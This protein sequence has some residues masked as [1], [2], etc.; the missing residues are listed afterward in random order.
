[1]ALAC[2]RRGQWVHRSR[3]ADVITGDELQVWVSPEGSCLERCRGMEE[4]NPSGLGET[5]RV[6][7]NVQSSRKLGEGSLA[8]KCDYY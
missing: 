8:K 7:V 3:H 5:N 4:W 1:M 6:L 2:G